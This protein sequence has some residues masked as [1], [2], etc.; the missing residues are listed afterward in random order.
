[1]RN[2]PVS[3]V[4]A[5]SSEPLKQLDEQLADP[6]E[7]HGK[8]SYEPRQDQAIEVTSGREDGVIDHQTTEHNY[9]TSEDQF[10]GPEELEGEL[11]MEAMG[12]GHEPFFFD[13]KR[14]APRSMSLTDTVNVPNHPELDDS[15]DSEEVI[16]FTGRDISTKTQQPSNLTMTQMQ[17]EIKVVEEEIRVNTSGDQRNVDT[18]AK[19]SSSRQRKT[20]RQYKDNSNEDDA[21]LADYIA[22][23]RESGEL[24]HILHSIGGNRRDLGGS[25]DGGSDSGRTEDTRHHVQHIPDSDEIASN[26]DGNTEA[27]PSRT[28]QLGAENDNDEDSSSSESEL[29]D[30]TLAK[31]IAGQDPNTVS[32]VSSVIDSSDSDSSETHSN[33]P[34]RAQEDFDL[35]DWDRPSLRRKRGKAGRAR[36]HLDISDTELEQ[37]LQVAWKG[38]R[39]KKSQRKKQREELRALGMLGK[40][41]NKPEDLRVKYPDGMDIMQVAEELKSF[42]L[43]CDER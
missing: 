36:L 26:N 10:I 37:S 9:E 29:D 13:V 7:Y 1:M 5:G 40:K 42:L 8:D 32:G 27:H 12:K 22:N 19:A 39:L 38:D 15:S 17:T 6:A 18:P 20:P 43:G 41:A 16:L 3:F 34:Q 33:Y 23:M 30:E 35:M 24:Q 4:S 11:R 25:D 21:L 28:R 31:L 2:K 14:E